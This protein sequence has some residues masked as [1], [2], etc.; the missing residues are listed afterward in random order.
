VQEE[1][2]LI[3]RK[4]NVLILALQ[5][6]VENGYAQTAERLQHE[7]GVAISKFE[8]VENIDLLRIVQVRSEDLGYRV[9][10]TDRG[11]L[12]FEGV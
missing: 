8:V 11:G 1:K 7:A 2:R 6:C 5:Y 10:S 9:S 4:R 12:Y 3:E